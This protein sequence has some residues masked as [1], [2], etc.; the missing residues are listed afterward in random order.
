MSPKTERE[1]ELR[2]LLDLALS[3]MRSIQNTLETAS[4]KEFAA[5]RAQWC[6]DI[7]ALL[8]EVRGNLRSLDL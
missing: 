4:P 5:K 7:E 8:D 2:A 6:N 1:Q 3:S